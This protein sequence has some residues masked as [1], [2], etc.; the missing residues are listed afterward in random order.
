[1]KYYIIFLIAIQLVLNQ[2]VTGDNRTVY[3]ENNGPI[4]GTGVQNMQEVPLTPKAAWI[5][6]H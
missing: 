5:N 3:W 2:A 6:N 4:M 1:M